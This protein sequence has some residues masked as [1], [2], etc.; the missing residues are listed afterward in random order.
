MSQNQQN[1]QDLVFI[2]GDLEQ[3]FITYLN[4]MDVTKLNL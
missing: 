3:L 2:V 1:Q 4:M